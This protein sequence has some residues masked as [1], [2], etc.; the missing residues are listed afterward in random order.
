MRC[1]R[2]GYRLPLDRRANLEQHDI[3]KR[4]L[5]A[6][7]KLRDY[8][9]ESIAQE[10][11]NAYRS[12]QSQKTSLDIYTKNLEV[13]QLN[14]KYAKL[15]LESGSTNRDVLEAQQ[16]LTQTE[17]SILSAKTELYLATLNLKNAMGED[18]ITTGQ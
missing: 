11:G 14:L 13:A 1:I 9:T 12:V 17:A 15:M 3:A 7:R 18:L 6:L 16:A 2:F 5:E 10:V 4:Q 8:Q